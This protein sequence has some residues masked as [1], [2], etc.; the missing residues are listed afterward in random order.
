[1]DG[2]AGA[3]QGDGGNTGC[4]GVSMICRCDCGR[5]SAGD[6]QEQANQWLDSRLPDAAAMGGRRRGSENSCR[7]FLVGKRAG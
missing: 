7:T 6:E 3:T 4:L 1:M 5:G 2:R